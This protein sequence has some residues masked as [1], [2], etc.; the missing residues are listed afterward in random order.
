MTETV[1]PETTLKDI[2]AEAKV[3]VAAVSK[4]L[5]N[6]KGVSDAT[7]RRVLSAAENLGYRG[8]AA[9]QLG[10]ARIVTLENYVSNDVFY[11]DILAS[12]S[13]SGPHQGLEIGMS[14]FRNLDEMMARGNLP[15][16]AQGVLLV[17][18]D[19][20]D[21]I[22]RLA[23]AQTPAVIINGMDRTM[24]LS[25]ISPDYHYG[26]WRATRH[27]L[28]MGHRDIVHVT[29]PYRESVRRRIDGFRNAMEEQGICFEPSR[30]ILDLGKAQN[31][32][33]AAGD[34]VNEWL[35]AGNKMPTAFFCVSD[36]VALGVM[37]ALQQRGTLVPED[38]SVI[39]FDGLAFGANTTPP[40]TSM[41]S[42]RAALGRI[43]VELLAQQ[44]T[45]P[46]ALVQRIT[47]GVDLVRRRSTAEPDTQAAEQ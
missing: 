1:Q 27:L 36:M 47:V 17:G 33:L 18:V 31:I 39:G 38:V 14:V 37:Q 28:D 24:R 6:R 2:A 46:A 3:S 15:V 10:S 29:H 8:R 13:A 26:A 5:N 25:S 4:V 44:L 19:H 43:G 34:V 42:D 16:Q 11:G 32:S 40:L 30:H 9:R 12:I 41:Q 22:D 35:N 7:R 21:L 45:D 23:E 20:L